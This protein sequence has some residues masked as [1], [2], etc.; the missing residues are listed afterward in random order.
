MQRQYEVM[1]IINS[2]SKDAEKGAF[3]ARFAKLVESIGGKASAEDFWG[4]RNFSYPIKKKTSGVYTVIEFTL[5][6]EKLKE[7]DKKLKL[8]K[9]VVRYM[10]T[11][12]SRP[13]DGRPLGGKG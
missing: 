8:E 7:L 13:E 4:V 2:D 10:L 3:F 5:D 11:Q 1:A 9:E 12:S 6:G